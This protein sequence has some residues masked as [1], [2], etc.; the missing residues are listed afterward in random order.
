MRVILSGVKGIYPLLGLMVCVFLFNASEFLPVSLLTDIAKDLG[1][2][3]FQA[4][5]LI[6]VYAWAVAILS[7][8][9]MLVLRKMDYKKM[10]LICVLTF[11]VFQAM[12]GLSESYWV[13]MVSRIGVAVSH[14]IFWSIVTP[15]AVNVVDPDHKEA[16]VGAI[17]VGICVALVLGLPLGR[18]IGLAMDWRWSFLSIAVVSMIM[19]V[20]MYLLLPRQENPGTFTLRRVPDLFR[21]RTLV[22]IYIVLVLIVTGIF[23]GYSYIEPFLRNHAMSSESEVTMLMAVFGIAGAVGSILFSRAFRGHRKVLFITVFAGLTLSLLLLNPLSGMFATAVAIIFF[24]GFC[25]ILL[26]ASLQALLIFVS[27]RDAVPI[28]M[29]V[30]SG[31]YNTGIAVGSLIGGVVMTGLGIQYIGFVGAV[32][33][34][35]STMLMFALLLPRLEV[36]AEKFG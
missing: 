18:V 10:F 3:D 8:P 15:I 31:L 34:A 4:G 2:S 26:G 28:A 6:A 9:I 33:A 25:Y 19:L 5:L 24:W 16:A 32:F 27:P 36:D 29:S 21:D 14:S 7:L 17:S 30:Y 35:V 1:I 13:L 20:A 22:G 11:A 12:S 23:T